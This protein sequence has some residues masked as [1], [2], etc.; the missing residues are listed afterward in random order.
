VWLIVG[1]GNPGRKYQFTRHNIGFRVIDRLSRELSIPLNKKSLLTKWGKGTWGENELVLA[2]P[3]TFMNLSG[4]AVIRLVKFFQ[5]KTKNMIV[6][7]DDLDLSLGE[8]RIREKG[9]G[10]GHKGVESII[11]SLETHDFI[12]V[13]LGIG[14][15]EKK[16]NEKDYVL[17]TFDNREKE[18]LSKQIINGKEAVKIIICEG[19]AIAMNRFN[20]K[21]N[22]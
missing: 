7:H 5:V 13:R 2:K 12:R 21:K 8:I 16:G 9:G 22:S 4:E 1:L 14:R 15:P 11:H 17:G 19:T 10:G 3:Q 18:I 6:I 20:R